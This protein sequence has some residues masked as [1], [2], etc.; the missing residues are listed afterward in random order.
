VNSALE[1]QGFEPNVDLRSYAAMAA[2]G[3]ATEAL[4]P[5]PKRGPASIGRSRR[6]E[7]DH[8]V[9]NSLGGKRQEEIRRHNEKAWE[10]WE[11]RRDLERAKAREDGTSEKIAAAR[12]AER[13]GKAPDD[14]T[15][16]GSATPVGASQ[17]SS[18]APAPENECR[19]DP[20]HRAIQDAQAGREPASNKPDEFDQVIDPESFE[21]PDTKVA[22]RCEI[23]VIVHDLERV[24]KRSE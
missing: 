16:V 10:A 5:Q 7:R 4:V 24:R 19:D 15:E 18:V 2:A 23:R 6:L 12:E 22:P 17:P 20:M 21:S 8:G 1:K 9:D 11:L 3:D 14:A 13:R